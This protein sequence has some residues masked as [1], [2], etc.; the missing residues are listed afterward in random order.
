LYSR[1][2]KIKA[3]EKRAKLI[4]STLLKTEGELAPHEIEVIDP[5]TCARKTHEIYVEPASTADSGYFCC[6]D[7][8]HGPVS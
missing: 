8:Q 4:A 3:F 5:V 2:K 6:V 1:K 7:N